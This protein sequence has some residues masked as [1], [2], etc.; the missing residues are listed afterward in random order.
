MADNVL[1]VAGIE[2]AYGLSQVLFGVSLSVAPGEM[3]TLMGRNGMGKT[4]LIAQLCGQLTPDS[5]RIRFAGRDIT[6]LPMYRRGLL[7]L[8][9]SFQITSLFL[10]LSVLDN[11]AL[12]TQAHAGHSFRFW[13]NA[14][15]E[16][17]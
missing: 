12:A 10:G 16:S 1:D 17:E 11:V 8:A 7:G 3:V 15:T 14:R 2:T 6:A 4:T 9:R 13:R 5:G